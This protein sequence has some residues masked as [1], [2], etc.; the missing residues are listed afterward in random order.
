MYY[1]IRHPKFGQGQPVWGG[2]GYLPL[3]GA[4]PGARYDPVGP[5]PY[6]GDIGSQQQHYPNQSYAHPDVLY[7]PGTGDPNANDI[8]PPSGVPFGRGRG[9]DSVCDSPTIF[10]IE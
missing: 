7:P 4:P 3:G 2:D 5:G 8:G 9:G 6:C 1:D 10:E